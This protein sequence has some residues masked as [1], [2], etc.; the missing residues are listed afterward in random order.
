MQR[1]VPGIL[2]LAQHIQLLA[3]DPQRYRPA[4]CP[5]CQ[6]SRPWG[7]GRYW[8]KADR[9]GD[10]RAWLNPVWFTA[11]RQRFLVTR[12]LRAS[13]VQLPRH[14]A[15]LTVCPGHRPVSGRLEASGVK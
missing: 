7:Q 1:I 10:A 12:L 15:C 2:S 5:H 11:M 14:S 8:R 4:H 3:E 13:L 6:T 9:V